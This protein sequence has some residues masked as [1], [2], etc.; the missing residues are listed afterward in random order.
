MSDHADLLGQARKSRLVL[1]RN[2]VRAL[3]AEIAENERQRNLLLR[4][5]SDLAWGGGFH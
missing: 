4:A 2:L 3:E 5:V 1:V